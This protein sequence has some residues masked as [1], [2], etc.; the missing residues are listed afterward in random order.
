MR[1]EETRYGIRVYYCA[2]D[3]PGVI[4]EAQEMFWRPFVGWH[5]RL[6]ISPFP[7]DPR[8]GLDLW[9][10]AR[11]VFDGRD[12]DVARLLAAFQEFLDECRDHV[13]Q[14]RFARRCHY[15]DRV[16][17]RQQRQAARGAAVGRR[18]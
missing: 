12:D 10:D 17:Q 18:G 1:E 15:P 2:C 9:V 14:P 3:V 5:A 4:D 16:T 6:R 7:T 13:D 8:Y 11:W